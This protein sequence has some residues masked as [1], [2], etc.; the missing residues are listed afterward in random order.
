MKIITVMSDEHSYHMMRFINHS[1]LKTPNLDRLASQ[2]TVF[3]A[4]YT[5]CPV[6][7]PARA[8]FMAGQYIN[9]LG[10]WDNSTPYDGS[11][12]GLSHYLTSHGISYAC[13]GKTHFHPDG[14]YQFSHTGFPGYM[15]RPDIGC[16]FRDQKTGRVGAE[17]RFEKIGLKTEESYDDKVLASSLSWLE[18]HSQ[19]ES[20]HLY[21]GFLDPHF[22]F[23][24]KEENWNYF[25]SLISEVPNELKPPFSSLNE[26]LNWLQ[27]Y[28][29]CETVP[30]ETIRKLLIGYHC[31]ITELDER[32][33]ILLNKLEE[34]KLADQTIV[35]YTSDHGEQLG[36]HGLWWKCT[37]FEQ[38][39]HVPMIVH[40]PGQ[41]PKRISEPINL[42]DWFPTVCD[43]MNL[44]IPDG[45]D[46]HSLKPFIE[47]GTS[48]CHPDFAFSEYHAHGV[49]HGMFMIRWKHYKYIYYCYEKPQLFDLN[50]DPGENHSLLDS[51]MPSPAVMITAEECH[52][53]LLSICNPYEVDLR[54]KTFQA[55]T[56]KALGITE[57]DTD[58][59]NCPVPH[60][61]AFFS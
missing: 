24:V 45:L 39:A 23:Y 50:Q 18:D 19:E 20:W 27:T 34:L 10:T 5:P 32:I 13:I 43:F 48:S 26:P 42:T 36:Y 21:I 2:S 61:K 4:C 53:R 11:V 29:K 55:E 47:A 6:C 35:C 41:S 7:A 57:Y 60:P 37:M 44:P 30:E 54:A 59:G 17:K 52:K 14:S 15:N 28:F 1:I 56:K 12:P 31:A 38:S 3:D 9:R 8:S 51:K 16:F 49:P 33:G 40:V 22:P 46:G 25:E 58:M